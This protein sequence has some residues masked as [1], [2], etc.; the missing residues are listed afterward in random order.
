MKVKKR[1]GRLEDYSPDKINN[2]VNRCCDGLKVSP[3]EIIL[4]AEIS[5]R[6]KIPT[7]EIDEQLELTAR[8]KIWQHPD[9]GKAAARMLLSSH[10]KEV[11]GESVDCD[12]FD[13][14]YRSMFVRNIKKGVKKGIFDPRLLSFPLKELAEYIKPE[15][16]ELYGYVGIK[17]LTDRYFSKIDGKVIETPQ[18]FHMRVAM[19]LCINETEPDFV[20]ELYDL[21]SQHKA[22]PSTPTLFNSGTTHPQLSSCY[23]SSIDDSVD[24]IFE[25]LWQEA[26][27]S[28]YAGGLGFHMT[29]I[30]ST[31]SHIKGTNGTS[32]GLIPWLKV[33]ND[34]L[35]ACNQAGRRPGSGCVYLEP[36]H[37]DIEEFITLRTN[38]GDEARKCRQLN[39][40]LWI[41]DLFF[42]RLEADADWTLFDPSVV[43][44]LHETF[45][46]EFEKLYEKY[47][48]EGLGRTIKA[49]ALWKE[50]LKCLFET[51]HPWICFKDRCNET[52]TNKHE[53]I[54]HGSNLCTEICLRTKSPNYN[55][56]K[57]EVEG[58]TAVCTLSSICLPNHMLYENGRW[59]L[60]YDAI[61]ETI[62]MMVRALDNVISIN[63]YPTEEA[64][65]GAEADRPIGIGT[66]GW[67]DVYARMGIAPDS[68]E[69]KE[70]ADD[71]MQE[72][73]FAAVSTSAELASERGNYP[74][75]E[76]SD[77]SQGIFHHEKYGVDFRSPRWDDLRKKVIC[78][79]R[80]SNLLAIA[81]NASI[82]FILGYNQSIEPYYSAVYV[83]GNKS[84]RTMVINE[85]LV[86]DLESRNLWNI[87]I[88]KDIIREEGNLENLDIPEDIKKKYPTAFQCDQIGLIKA[89]AARQKWVD[90]AISFNLYNDKTSLKY[91]N[92]IYLEAW[93]SGLKT[94]YYLRNKRANSAEKMVEA[95]PQEVQACP[96]D[97]S[98][99]SCE[100]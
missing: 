27:K 26:R 91:L 87:D 16:D 59:S 19:G 98:C 67:A 58:L 34:M 72:I 97:G 3:S 28:K 4:D 85:R 13:N 78:G 17:N 100:G 31:G 30:R 83:Y 52:Y 60:D 29:S 33:Y 6:D 32:S 46:L 8:S 57:K 56:G 90:Q 62:G 1:N 45:G 18:A 39:T 99:E 40:A 81:P 20:Y 74:T 75:F 5:F 23:L 61:N 84:G 12:T 9:Y 96:I 44:D 92:D 10:Y 2:F 63:F 35:V 25:G 38:T 86:E 80:N 37:G 66:I 43:P 14:D 77:W 49:K 7:S 88:A 15:R 82:G 22:S 71:L 50:I 21:Y 93:K 95:K 70:L 55:E 48:S 53:G 65:I 47:E 76:G 73:S 68:N 69:A 51:S 79:M 11:I 64:R 94:T 54:I 41:P 42:K 24:G 36:W 89:N